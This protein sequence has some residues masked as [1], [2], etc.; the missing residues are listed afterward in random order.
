MLSHDLPFSNILQ[1]AKSV[2]SESPQ[3]G[4]GKG[5]ALEDLISSLSFNPFLVRKEIPRT[6]ENLRKSKPLVF[7]ILID[8][9]CD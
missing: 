5:M 2:V 1:V 7:I 8:E 4:E 6:P 9:K 3:N